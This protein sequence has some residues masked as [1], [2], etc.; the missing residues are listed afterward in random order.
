MPKK[1]CTRCD[2]EY[3]NS[4]VSPT[5]HQ[6]YFHEQGDAKESLSTWSYGMTDMERCKP[7]TIKTFKELNSY[8]LCL[9][10]NWQPVQIIQQGVT[11][12]NPWLQLATIA[13][14]SWIDW[15]FSVTFL[16][17]FQQVVILENHLH[18]AQCHLF[19]WPYQGLL[20]KFPAHYTV[21]GLLH[22]SLFHNSTSFWHRLYPTSLF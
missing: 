6:A 2:K 22:N 8:E 10:A 4:K 12:H 11:C 14:T 5:R 20:L 1:V 16:S 18:F 15:S 7:Q 17:S 19:N 3:H 9:E 21:V 13:A